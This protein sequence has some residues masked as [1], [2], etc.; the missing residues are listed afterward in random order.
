MSEE[1]EKDTGLLSHVK[2]RAFSKIG[3]IAIGA[4]V[5]IVLL[6]GGGTYVYAQQ[7]SGKIGPNVWIADIDVSGMDPETARQVLYARAEEL[8][9]A[10]LPVTFSGERATLPL[11]TIVADDLLDDVAIDIDSAISAALADS[12]KP[13]PALDSAHVVASLLSRRTFYPTV[14]LEEERLTESLRRLYPEKETFAENAGFDISASGSEWTVDVTAPVDGQEFALEDFFAQVTLTLERMPA[15]TLEPLQLDLHTKAAEIR[16]RDAQEKEEEILAIL[17]RAPF[18]LFH[19]EPGRMR[20]WDLTT[21]DLSVMLALAPDE[22]GNVSITLGGESYDAYLEN[23]AEEVNVKPRNA[24]FEIVEGKVTE[25]IGSIPGTELD[26]ENTTRAIQTLFTSEETRIAIATL[27]SAPEVAT[28]DVNDLGISELLGVGISDYSNSPP[29]RISNI[30]NAVNLLNGTLIAPDE[31]FSLVAALSPFTYENG[32]LPELVIKGD[33]IEPEMGGGACQIGTTTFRATMNSG[34][35]VVERRNHSL[36]VDHY[37]DPSN[38]NPGTD[39]TIYEIRPGVGGPDYRFK[40][41][42]GHYILFQAEMLT[43]TEELRFS[44]WGT[45]DGRKGSY[46]PPVVHRWIGA[47]A[48]REVVTPDLAPGQRKCQGAFAGAEAS[49][50]YTIERADGTKEETV[51]ESHYRSLPTICLVGESEESTEPGEEIVESET[52]EPEEV[53]E[54][55]ASEILSEPTE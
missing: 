9:T 13:H 26:R 12:H 34:L 45:S 32:F 5:F 14:K 54:E 36:V 7:F 16:E 39:A 24:K 8:L 27:E 43:E 15:G 10:G 55:S 4:A 31:T 49:F 18:E 42:T 46:T 3:L 28:G 29:N 6:A 1:Q 2:S 19:E 11:T 44:F 30:R 47:G 51:F 23:I 21:E 25:F 52:A 35:E 20:E 40:N 22:E 48:L 50:T 53:L 38:G 33:K 41:D 37:N 17:E